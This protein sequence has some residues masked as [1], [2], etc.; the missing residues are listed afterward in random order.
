MV[1]K[2]NPFW[3]NKTTLICLAGQYKRHQTNGSQIIQLFRV[4]LFT[5][6]Y[7]IIP[8]GTFSCKSVRLN[9][10]GKSGRK[11][12]FLPDLIRV[13]GFTGCT[14]ARNLKPSDLIW[15]SNELPTGTRHVPDYFC[16]IP[17]QSRPQTGTSRVSL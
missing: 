13:Y 15:S 2:E 14:D 6:F 3:L 4:L 12:A 17:E 5:Q 9:L 8:Q 16:L 7:P 1:N 10:N 11:N